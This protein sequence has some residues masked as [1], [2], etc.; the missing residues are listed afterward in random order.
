MIKLKLKISL[1]ISYVN[2]LKLKIKKNN[3]L[4]KKKCVGYPVSH[5]QIPSPTFAALL[6]TP[7]SKLQT[8]SLSSPAT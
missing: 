7:E 8:L 4:D 1:L 5:T 2:K 3:S 6:Y